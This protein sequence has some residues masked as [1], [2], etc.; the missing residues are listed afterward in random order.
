M[1]RALFFILM[2]FSVSMVN[3][4]KYVVTDGEVFYKIGNSAEISA[5]WLDT[6]P[7]EDVYI[8]MSPECPSFTIDNLHTNKS[9]VRDAPTAWPGKKLKDCINSPEPD[10]QHIAKNRG[11]KGDYTADPKRGS[12][13]HYLC[14]FA[15]EYIDSK[16][17][18]FD[19]NDKVVSDMQ[20]ALENLCDKINKRSGKQYVITPPN[21]T[22]RN[23]MS[24]LDTIF[25]QTKED[26]MVF[27]YLSSHGEYDVNGNFNFIVKDSRYN[28]SNKLIENALSKDLINSIVNLLTDKGVSVL[29]FVD[30]CNA[31]DLAADDRVRGEAAYYLSTRKRSN[32]FTDKNGSHFARVLI[33]AM[34]GKSGNESYSFLDGI[35]DVGS[36]GLYLENSVFKFSNHKQRP[37]SDPH[38][39]ESSEILWRNKFG[40]SREVLK[41]KDIVN[42]KENVSPSTRALAMIALGDAYFNGKDIHQENTKKSLDSAFIWYSRAERLKGVDKKTRAKA[43]YG[44]YNY[45]RDVK[46]PQNAIEH[47]QHAASIDKHAMCDLGFCYIDGYGVDKDYK[48]AIQLIKKAAK[49]KDAY[50][51]A[52]WYLGFLYQQRAIAALYDI[53]D[54]IY[55]T[56]KSN[57]K[58]EF[59]ET[60]KKAYYY[61]EILG[62]CFSVV[63]DKEGKKHY[64]STFSGSS[65]KEY[66]TE[67]I[68]WYEKAIKNGNVQAKY[69]LGKIYYEGKLADKNA[70]L[71]LKLIQEAAKENCKDAITYLNKLENKNEEKKPRYEKIGL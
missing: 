56:S 11:V 33:D 61:S 3:A 10:I 70:T 18:S 58:V 5:G 67:S 43:H 4:D 9:I 63:I 41:N 27:L 26:D 50:S 39:Y 6:I 65:F 55:L 17:D 44:L 47:L 49:G 28:R 57:K 71:G 15:N 31:G 22:R 30:A 24:C 19:D 21:A 38:D 37:Y 64:I 51:D 48:K 60:Y 52:Q 53:L 36:L 13:F 25:R 14:V 16:W 20:V 62:D 69:D 66:M 32:A 2:A 46:T 8:R 1:K 59:N 40:E 68:S 23:I 34:N 7:N 29:L 54:Y 12:Q 42:D 35:V 45:Y